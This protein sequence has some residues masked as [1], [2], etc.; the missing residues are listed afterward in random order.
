MENLNVFFVPSH[1]IGDSIADISSFLNTIKKQKIDNLLWSESGYKPTVDFAIAY[2]ENN[3]LLKYF[4]SEKYFKADFKQIND[5][6][7]QDSC[8]E[9]FIAFG[10]DE[11]YYNLEFN[12]L[13]TALIAY[14]SGKN[15]RNYSDVATVAQIQSKHN[16]TSTPNKQGDTEWELTLNIPFTLFTHHNITSLIGESC[17]ANFYK[18]GDDLP[19]PHFI[20]WSVID[21]PT[22]NFHLP[23]F[24]G[25]ILFDK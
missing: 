3:I 12:A 13:G 5:P 4:V 11:S 14:G 2:T 6:V 20:S 10:G 16:I 24:F 19:V 7:Y 25:T 23:Q 21:Y 1:V 18:C 17:R 9:F 22:P 8:V 15:D